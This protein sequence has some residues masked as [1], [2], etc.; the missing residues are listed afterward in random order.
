MCQRDNHQNDPTPLMHYL[1]LN[2]S[3]N[4]GRLLDP[5]AG[6]EIQSFDVICATEGV[7]IFR[8]GQDTGS[9]QILSIENLELIGA[10][11]WDYSSNHQQLTF[12]DYVDTYLAS[13]D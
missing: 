4:L 9:T 13:G 5:L 2:L 3:M 10:I 12:K 8:R 1:R 7:M 6:A 11:P